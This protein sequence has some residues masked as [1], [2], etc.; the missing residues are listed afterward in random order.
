MRANDGSVP[1]A[2]GAGEP[3]DEAEDEAGSAISSDSASFVV[4]L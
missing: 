3:G 4:L 2:V 1:I